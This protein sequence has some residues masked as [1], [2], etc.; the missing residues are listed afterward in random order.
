MTRVVELERRLAPFT[1]V[2]DF[3]QFFVLQ[4]RSMGDEQSLI[5]RMRSYCRDLHDISLS[6]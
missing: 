3:E 1:V 5:I 6:P 2:S 4:V